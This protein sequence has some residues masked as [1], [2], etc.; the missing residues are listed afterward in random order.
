LKLGVNKSWNGFM[1]GLLFCFS[2]LALTT[3]ASEGS[4]PIGKDGRPLNLDFEDGTL[5]DW[6]A[7]GKAFEN[8]PI[9]G[10]TV[11]PRR[12]DMRSEHQG[13]YWIGT[14]EIAGDAPQGTLT[15]SSFK[16]TRPY[17][18]FLV[19]GGAHS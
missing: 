6:V 9:K 18:T 10:D 5:R 12:A 16:V 17:A 19:A 8:Q 14:Y 4:L 13:N 7:I 15:S 2:S 11:A 3:A 1:L